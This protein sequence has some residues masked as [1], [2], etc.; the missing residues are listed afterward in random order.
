MLINQNNLKG[1][2]DLYKAN[3]RKFCDAWLYDMGC[4]NIASLN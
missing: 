3:Q 4:Y 2:K 1:D